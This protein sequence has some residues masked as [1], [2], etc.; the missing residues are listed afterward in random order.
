MP[1][2]IVVVGSANVD[3]VATAP[4]IPAPGETVIGT[5]FTMVCG[6]KG[7]NQAIAAARLDAQVCFVGRLGQDMFGDLLDRSFREAG[8]NTDFIRRDPNATTGIAVIFVGEDGENSIIVALGANERVSSNDVDVARTAIAQA[9]AVVLQ[10]EIPDAPV[11]RAIELAQAYGAKIILN[12]APARPVEIE[13]LKRC[14]VI[15]PNEWE[16]QQLTG[17][18]VDNIESA[19]AASQQLVNFGVPAVVLTLGD[20]GAVLATT[21]GVEHIP[22]F[23]VNAVDTTAAGDAFTGA[24]AVRWC[25]G[26][27]LREAVRFANAAGALATTKMGAQPSLPRRDEVERLLACS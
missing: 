6:G 16:A 17:M 26:V 25:E 14:S 8:I 10:L 18:K 7:A 13:L 19:M 15:T 27:P 5:G 11:K 23:K 2:R 12:P 21:D 24:L 4:R 20:Q 9:D 1:V 22:A 3:M